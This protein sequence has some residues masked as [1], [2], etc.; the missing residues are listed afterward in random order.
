MSTKDYWLIAEVVR[1][2]VPLSARHKVAE[3][4][5][6]KLWQENERFNPT[7]FVEVCLSKPEQEC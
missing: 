5:A 1:D 3:V 2:C 4:F 7:I 6:N